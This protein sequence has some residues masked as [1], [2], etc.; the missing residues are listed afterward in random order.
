MKNEMILRF[1]VV[2]AVFVESVRDGE[3]GSWSSAGVLSSADGA[4]WSLSAGCRSGR[5]GVDE[6]A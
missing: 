2:F 4:E 5:E 3:R 6:L 1:P